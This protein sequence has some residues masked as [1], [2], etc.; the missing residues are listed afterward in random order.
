[1][2]K[3]EVGLVMEITFLLFIK[4]NTGLG[5]GLSLGLGLVLGL[6]L[7][8]SLSLCLNLSL[9]YIPIQEIICINKIHKKN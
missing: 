2:A 8:L 3:K 4:L 6:S 7:G 5:L 9:V 1:M